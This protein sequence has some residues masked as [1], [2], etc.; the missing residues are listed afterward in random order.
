MLFNSD[1]EHK[2]TAKKIFSLSV[3]FSL[4]IIFLLLPNCAYAIKNISSSIKEIRSKFFKAEGIAFSTEITGDKSL[5]LTI[6]AK[7]ITLPLQQKNIKNIEIRCDNFNITNNLFSCGSCSMVMPDNLFSAHVTQF[8]FSYNLT[9]NE[10]KSEISNL[11][12]FGE[13]HQLSISYNSDIWHLSAKGKADLKEIQPSLKKIGVK[14]PKI[15]IQGSA[16][17][18]LS[19]T[20]NKSAILNSSANISIP[21]LTYSAKNGSAI[22]KLSA[23]LRLNSYYKENKYHFDIESKISDGSVFVLYNTPEKEEQNYVFDNSN[24]TTTTSFIGNYNPESS[25]LNIT[26]L[27]L[28]AGDIANASGTLKIN[29]AKKQLIQNVNLNIENLNIKNTLKRFD[30]FIGDFYLDKE[31][32]ALAGKIDLG[33]KMKRNSNNVIEIDTRTTLNEI[34][35]IYKDK[36]WLS[37]LSGIINWNNLRKKGR[38][39]IKWQLAQ[40]YKLPIGKTNLNFKVYKKNIEIDKANIPIF[41]GQLKLHSF[42]IQDLDS[43]MRKIQFGGKLTPVSL[44]KVTGQLGWTIIDG[45]I[46]GE[47]PMI[48]FFDNT[49]KLK[50]DLNINL[51]GGKMVINK[52][53]IEDLFGLIPRIY[54]N[55]EFNNFDLSEI[56]STFSF[57]RITGKISGYMKDLLVEDWQLARFDAKIS[58]PDDDKSSHKISQKAVDNLSSIGGVGGALS[59]TYLS[60]FEQFSY[61]KIGIACK[62]ENGICKMSGVKPATRGYYIVVGSWIPRIDII[63]YQSEVNW[64]DFLNKLK[65]AANSGGAKLSN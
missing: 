52:L 5:S 8:S 10:L 55:I 38:S 57:G 42:S 59:R 37:K 26:N 12:L 51:F 40:I 24:M 47:L 11:I 45:V 33:L 56:T 39:F 41:D 65:A 29:L 61:D 62:L 36:I 20:G 18:S 15:N 28:K 48:T 1:R 2:K 9:K 46:S 35:A 64:G 22:E 23:D 14:F 58:N 13:K 21:Q 60:L 4:F 25:V 6:K 44:K 17:Y 53:K 31:K 7:T 43:S 30:L 34:Y 16:L 3:P 27:I 54:G 19:L 32:I 49:I 63:G 50:G